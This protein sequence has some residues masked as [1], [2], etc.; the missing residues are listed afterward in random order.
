VVYQL[1]AKAIPVILGQHVVRSTVDPNCSRFA[2]V[3]EQ[4][5][6]CYEW[7]CKREVAFPNRGSN[8]I[9]DSRAFRISTFAE[10][11]LIN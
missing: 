3:S 6:Q 4:N 7:V 2:R 11:G 1:L 9:R 8:P 10:M 5:T